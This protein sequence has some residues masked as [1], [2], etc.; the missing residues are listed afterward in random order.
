MTVI[1]AQGVLDCLL[2]LDWLLAVGQLSMASM[3]SMAIWPRRQIRRWL[4][5]IAEPMQMMLQGAVRGRCACRKTNSHIQMVKSAEEWR[6]HNA[7]NGMN[8]AR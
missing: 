3:A 4:P 7:A 1:D 8:S 2:P 6:L 5:Y